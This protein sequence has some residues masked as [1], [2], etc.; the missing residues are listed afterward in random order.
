[1]PTFHHPRRVTIEPGPAMWPY[2]LC[3][4]VVIVLGIGTFVADHEAAITGL[5]YAVL[6]VLGTAAVG[7]MVTLAVILHGQGSLPTARPEAI[8]QAR[9]RQLPARARVGRLPARARVGRL[10]APQAGV[11]EPT[12]I[13]GPPMVRPGLWIREGIGQCQD[14]GATGGLATDG[15]M[16][17]HHTPHP[18]W[19]ARH[20]PG[21]SGPVDPARPYCQ[22]AR[23]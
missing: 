20:A 13:L 3:G 23:P 8:R 11:L 7:G 15:S 16:E 2:A 21:W 22:G 6:T 19:L 1:V 10:P 18:A 14:C 17:P 9:V 12:A 4:I 5:L